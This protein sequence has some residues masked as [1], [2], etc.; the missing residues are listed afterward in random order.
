M[1]K[2]AIDIEFPR[3]PDISGDLHGYLKRRH[4]V[5]S[6]FE[7]HAEHV[8][9][10]GNP[11]PNRPPRHVARFKDSDDALAMF[12]GWRLNKCLRAVLFANGTRWPLW[13]A[14]RQPDAYRDRET[15]E[16]VL[17]GERWRWNSPGGM[18]TWE[19]EARAYSGCIAAID[20]WLSDSA[21]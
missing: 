1:P 3:L 20:I 7:I 8:D 12:Y 19:V 15:N 2:P 6:G 14:V 5:A 18:N 10:N 11:L 4:D 13:L 17:T 9:D 16:H 21:M